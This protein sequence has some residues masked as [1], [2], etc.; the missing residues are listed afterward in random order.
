MDKPLDLS[1][2]DI[3]FLTFKSD[4]ENINIYSLIIKKSIQ[5]QQCNIEF[6]TENLVTRYEKQRITYP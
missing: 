1:N 6:N 4:L 3:V 5:I 2:S